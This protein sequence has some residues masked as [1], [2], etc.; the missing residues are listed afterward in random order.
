MF[1]VFGDTN[2]HF[3]GC[4]RNW[5]LHPGNCCQ[6]DRIIHRVLRSSFLPCKRKAVLFNVSSAC[7]NGDIYLCICSGSHNSNE[8]KQN[9]SV[10]RQNNEGS[11]QLLSRAQLAVI[12]WS[13]RVYLLNRLD[14]WKT[15]HI[16]AQTIMCWV[17]RRMTVNLLDPSTS[18]CD[19]HSN[20]DTDPCT[21]PTPTVCPTQHPT[22]LISSQ[23][24]L[25]HQ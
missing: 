13:V 10:S 24:R 11:S 23:L 2:R 6:W 8:S 21:W 18:H 1:Q 19:P 5:R 16:T 7:F 3:G 4:V 20:P 14:S 22:S 15:R 9:V 25:R 17:V 12:T